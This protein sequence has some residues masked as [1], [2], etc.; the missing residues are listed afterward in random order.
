MYRSINFVKWLIWNNA[1]ECFFSSSSFQILKVEKNPP[2]MR[3]G[4]TFHKSFIWLI[5]YNFR[6]T[7]HP[8]H[9][10]HLLFFRIKKKKNTKK[11]NRKG[12]NNSLLIVKYPF[13]FWILQRWSLNGGP[14]GLNKSLFDSWEKKNPKIGRREKKNCC[15]AVMM[16][17]FLHFEL[18]SIF[19]N[20]NYYRWISCGCGHNR[21][22]LMGPVKWEMNKEK[23]NKSVET[24]NYVII[25]SLPSSSER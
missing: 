25:L 12:N 2:E 13:A 3:K 6:T 21:H 17:F 22:F 15:Y 7:I 23:R 4:E 9:R 20:N 16:T 14:G 24:S 18:A 10:A 1:N 19:G 11:R 5:A 8:I